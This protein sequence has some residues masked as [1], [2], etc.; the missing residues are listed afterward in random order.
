MGVDWKAGF[1]IEL[2]AP[3]G[4][5]RL[6]LAKRVAQR[7]GGTIRRTFHAQAELSSIEGKPTFQ[8]L[9]PGFDVIDDGGR[10]IARFVDDLTLIEGFDLEAPALPGW[11]RIVTDDGRLISLIEANCDPDAAQADV[12]EPVAALFRSALE[13]HSSGMVKVSDGK[14][15]SV[16]IAAELSAER[17]RGCEIVT[18]PIIDNHADVLAALLADAVAEGF[19]VPLEAALHI[20]FD[21][22]PLLSA[23][24]IARLVTALDRFSE[25]LKDLV[26]TNPNCRRL[27]LWPDA[28]IDLVEDEDFLAL[29]WP[30]ARRALQEL[31]LTKFCDFNLLNIA[32]AVKGKHTFEV[33]ILPVSLV[34]DEIV[35]QAALFAAILR[36]A[37]DG[38]EDLPDDLSGFLEMLPLAPADRARWIGET[39]SQSVGLAARG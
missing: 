2:V 28:L 22:V 8:N 36:W 37:A 14:G 6:D 5:S 21:A 3:K 29:D 23:P 1:E 12:L 7:T 15:S 24:T 4:K 13:R 27:G 20:H 30:D 34:A 32:Q 33:R 39:D 10:L 38:A 17:E 18:P 31:R 25:E 19:S 16:A 11:Y 9:T 35:A 26:G